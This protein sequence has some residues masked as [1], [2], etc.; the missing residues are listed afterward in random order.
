M[1]KKTLTASPK[2]MARTHT[3]THI[4]N[5]EFYMKCMSTF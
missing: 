4:Y 1:M 3:H 2:N 5:F